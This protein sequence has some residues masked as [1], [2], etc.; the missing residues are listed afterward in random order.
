[1]DYLDQ[2]LKALAPKDPGLAQTLAQTSPPPGARLEPGRKG[3][4]CLIVGKT[5]LC[6]SVDPVDEGQRLAATAPPGPLVVFGFGL[7]YHLD[8]L[9]DRDLV[10]YEPD[11]GVLRLALEARDLA[12]VLERARLVLEPEQLLGLEGRALLVHPPSARLHPVEL[13]GLKRRLQTPP[14]RP[15]RPAQPRVLVIPPLFGGSLPVA[16]WCAQALAQLG[17][18]VSIPPLESCYPLYDLVRQ[19]E[20]HYPEKRLDRVRAPLVNFLSEL[21]VL[22]AETQKPHLCLVLA[23]APLNRRAVEEISRLGAVTA[24]WFIENYRHMTYYREL[25]SGYDHFFHIQGPALEAELDRL[26][27]NHAFLPMAAHPP[28]HR[29]LELD[30]QERRLYGAAVGFMGAGY[31]NRFRF[32]DELVRAGLDFRIWGTGWP[33]SGPLAQRVALGGRR[34]ESEEVT[35]VYNACSVVLNLHAS[36]DPGQ[37]VGGG[38]FVNPRTFEVPA[39]GGFQLVD[40]VEG[41]ERFFRPGREL[42]VFSSRRELVELAHHYLEHPELRQRLAAAGRRRVLAEHTYY[43]RMES[44]LNRCLGPAA[45]DQDLVPSQDPTTKAALNLLHELAPAGPGEQP[46]LPRRAAG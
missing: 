15:S 32:F 25:A 28:C 12:R 6:S 26:G 33:Q 27:A 19:K 1:M 29:P 8:F 44:L 7:G 4:P 20:R 14:A 42:A 34:L 13:Q 39:C 2:N 23:Q 11:P 30:E 17:C 36:P 41:L 9:L 45:E 5:R 22:E 46:P 37:P 21:A 24:F 18:Q 31:P 35:K 16:H 43:H 10:V 3:L 38:D 40:R